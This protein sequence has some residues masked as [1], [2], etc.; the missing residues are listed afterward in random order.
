MPKKYIVRDGYVVILKTVRDGKEYD[1][2]FVGGDT[3][4]LDD[5][6]AALHLHK[7]EFADS[8]DRDAALRAEVAERAKTAA[9]NPTQL[10]ADLVAA[11]SQAQQANAAAPE[12]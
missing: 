1:R 4:S 3:L 9:A 7:L 11:L 2:T 5:D 6:D 10:I 8:K 12:A